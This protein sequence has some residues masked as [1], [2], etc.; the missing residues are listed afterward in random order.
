[1][2]GTF[3]RTLPHYPAHRHH[4]SQRSDTR[5]DRPAG[6]RA[7]ALGPDRHQAPTANL[8]LVANGL[9]LK[10]KSLTT[11]VVAPPNIPVT[12]PVEI[13]IGYYSPAGSQRITQSY[14]RSTGN[15]VSL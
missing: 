10:Y 8:T 12:Q 13:S 1:M 7:T 5:R 2:P 15:P 3:S 6:R 4:Y 14:V 9:R 11:L